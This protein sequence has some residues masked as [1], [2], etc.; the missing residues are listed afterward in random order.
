MFEKSNYYFTFPAKLEDRLDFRFHHPFFEEAL[1]FIEQ[2]GVVL[3]P[4]LVPFVYNGSTP[5]KLP[6]EEVPHSDKVLF[7]KNENVKR[8]LLDL[9]NKAYISCS[10]YEAIGEEMR[11]K[12]DDIL[13]SMTG[14]LGNACLVSEEIEA[15]INQ[16]IVIL[17]CNLAELV[18]T[19][20]VRFLNS[21]FIE[22][23]VMKNYTSAQTPYLNVSKIK[24]LKII[25]PSVQIQRKI[26]EDIMELESQ[27]S[28]LDQQAEELI[29]KAE[30]TFLKNI[31]IIAR[32]NLQNISFY[33]KFD[34]PSDRL[35][36]IYNNPKYNVVDELISRAT[37]EFADLSSVVDFLQ[38]KRN[39]LE[40]P[41][42]EF[43]YVNIGNI[44]TKWGILNPTTMIGKDAESSRIR[45]V[46]YAGT[47]LVSTTRPTRNAIGIVPEDLDSQICSTGL[48][49]LRCKPNING[50]YLF[51]ALRTYLTRF[52]LERFCSGSGYPAI[53]Q[54]IDLPKI[55]IPLP[56]SLDRQCSIV[57]EVESILNEAKK[58]RKK[59]QGILQ[60]ALRQ[61][62]Q[63]LLENYHRD[64][65]FEAA[66]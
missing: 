46:M 31:G 28:E 66:P 62:T 59:S 21:E 38:D 11:I 48:A 52:Q 40:Q 37:V 39:P 51:H 30:E 61:F 6:S 23:Q 63:K 18:P 33:T 16:N 2:N 42:E 4:K 26:A 50:R 14:T 58:R 55:R 47:I 45:K 57:K 60:E 19:Y 10:D 53:N 13:F 32:I 25:K 64:S 29:S 7:I 49:V 8:L 44:D 9:E 35:D 27:A 3:Y 34:N 54:E 17:R 24:R 15:A 20:A 36:F 65:T 41:S 22:L 12:K 5:S 1:A 56:S 43:A